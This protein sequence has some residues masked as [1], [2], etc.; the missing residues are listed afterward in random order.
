MVLSA[1]IQLALLLAV[2]RHRWQY[3]AK[4]IKSRPTTGT[5]AACCTE[6]VP[7]NSAGGSS[8]AVGNCHLRPAPNNM[9][10]FQHS[11]QS[12]CSHSTRHNLAL[13][14]PPHNTW[15]KQ[16]TGPASLGN[17]AANSTAVDPGCAHLHQPTTWCRHRKCIQPIHQP[18]KVVTFRS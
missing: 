10:C 16:P 17:P 3:K 8:L 9:V 18:S 13:V 11:V 15:G 5:V 14:G 6:R 2:V 7:A 4:R 12:G 1:N